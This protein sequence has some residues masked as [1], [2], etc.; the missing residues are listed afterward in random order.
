MMDEEILP[1]PDVEAKQPRGRKPHEIRNSFIPVLRDR[2]TLPGSCKKIPQKIAK[3][4]KV[5]RLDSEVSESDLKCSIMEY[6]V[7]K[8][9]PANSLFSIECE[10]PET[11][12]PISRMEFKTIGDST[13]FG[14][15]VS[16]EQS[17]NVSLCKPTP[18]T[19]F[20]EYK[21]SR[22]TIVVRCFA[23][24]EVMKFCD[25]LKD[26]YHKKD[27]QDA[28][29]DTEESEIENEKIRCQRNLKKGLKT[30]KDQEK[31]RALLE[32]HEVKVQE[33]LLKKFKDKKQTPQ[34]LK[35]IQSRLK[36]S[37]EILQNSRNPLPVKRLPK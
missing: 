22:S 10:E 30:F 31:M 33:N 1:S 25:D 19:N 24:D 34:Q 2:S 15:E 36:E 16:V 14:E 11:I 18:V 4:K 9:T 37:Q 8:K 29:K 6:S 12:E 13:D 5:V 35:F 17:G 28:D 20:I 27:L 3:I 26:V 23:E 21:S 32:R 7:F